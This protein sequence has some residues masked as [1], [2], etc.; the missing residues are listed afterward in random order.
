MADDITTKLPPNWRAR[1]ADTSTQKL[2][3][4]WGVS[5]WQVEKL[6]LREGI[7]APPYVKATR[8]EKRAAPLASLTDTEGATPDSLWRAIARVQSAWQG[9]ASEQS[10][11]GMTLQDDAPVLVVYSSD[12]HVGHEWCDMARLE[13]D[14]RTVQETPGVYVVLGGD[15]IDN[16]ITASP[17]GAQFEGLAP[18]RIQK[19][20]AEHAL[21]FL[22]GR[23]IAVLLGNHEARSLRDDDFDF[24]AYLAQKTSAPYLGPIGLLTARLGDQEYHLLVGHRFR[25]NSTFNKTHAA[26]RAMELIA[27][28]DAVMLGDKHDAAGETSWVRQHAR[29]FAQAG[30][31][32]RHSRFGRSLGYLGAQPT[33][34]GVILFPAEHRVLGV[35]DSFVEGIH[36]LGSYRSDVHC[37]CTYCA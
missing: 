25:M 14:L 22:K 29:W 4:R 30:S 13:R 15:L 21:A 2:S 35:F 32:L 28:A 11:V 31:Y 37:G 33:M 1:L 19:L 23:V 5:R 6:R 12:W 3:E 27:D 7:P 16:V 9:L 18:P 26:K 34:P 17:P 10:E 36:M 24:C 8:A 20:L